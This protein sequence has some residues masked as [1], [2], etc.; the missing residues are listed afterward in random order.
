MGLG[1]SGECPNGGAP[2]GRS[3]K[4]TPSM[5]WAAVQMFEASPG[6]RLTQF[7]PESDLVGVTSIERLDRTY[8]SSVLPVR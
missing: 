6:P 8:F 2:R 5:R 4:G 1:I 3:G 7:E